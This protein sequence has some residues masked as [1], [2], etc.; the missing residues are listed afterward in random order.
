[1]LFWT[2]SIVSPAASGLAQAA[3][4]LGVALRAEGPPKSLR[5]S[6]RSTRPRSRG[7]I[8][9]DAGRPPAPAARPSC[10]PP[11]RRCA[12]TRCRTSRPTTRRPHDAPARPPHAQGEE[13]EDGA[14]RR[15]AQE[16]PVHE[17][18]GLGSA[19]HLSFVHAR[20]RLHRADDACGSCLRYL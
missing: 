6:A 17:R 7:S 11:P 15:V 2:A 10:P 20:R 8:R 4:T 3:A 18:D 12:S 14:R 19:L 16:L 9:T 1:M 5:W 13:A